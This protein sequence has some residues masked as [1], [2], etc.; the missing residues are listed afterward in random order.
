[1]LFEFTVIF[2]FL[3]FN[4]KLLREFKEEKL[5][6]KKLEEVVINHNKIIKIINK[7]S[8]KNLLQ[9]KKNNK[10]LIGQFQNIFD[11]IKKND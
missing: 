5:K 9:Y 10:F 11:L 1:M 8:K 7:N 6:I 4:V 2:I 3:M